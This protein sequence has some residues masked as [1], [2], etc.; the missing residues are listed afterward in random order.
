MARS[1]RRVVLAWLTT[2]AM[3]CTGGR[4][5]YPSPERSSTV[6][7]VADLAPE[8]A[9]QA[10][11]PARCRDDEGNAQPDCRTHRLVSTSISIE[12]LDAV[13]FAGNT[14]ELAPPSYRT[15]DHV[16]HTL[17][18][19]PS[20]RVIEVR[21]HGDSLFH[22]PQ[23][24]ELAQ[25]RA[26]VVAAYLVAHGVAASRLT[27]RGVSDREYRSSPGD[28]RNQQVEFVILAR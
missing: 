3:A 7:P 8:P 1:I 5:M 25:Q 24:A 22:A 16:A 11:V 20:I 6:P 4:P 23:R 12:V 28:P 27:I 21:G 9:W 15:L 26:E 2:L 17:I 14:A 19:N 10:Y 18:A 13:V